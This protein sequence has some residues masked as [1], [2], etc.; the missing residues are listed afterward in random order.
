L[1]LAVCITLGLVVFLVIGSRPSFDSIKLALPLLPAVL[2]FA[3]M[4]A[5]GENISYRAALLA[6]LHSVVGPSQAMLITATYFGISH[7]YG[8]PYGVIGVIMAGFLGWLL[9]KG[10]LETKGL[11]WPWFIHFCQDVAAFFFIAMGS[12]MAGG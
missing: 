8:I 1:I 11:F 12:V 2:L 3:A 5:F 6:P 9:S 7:Y 10:M 4:N